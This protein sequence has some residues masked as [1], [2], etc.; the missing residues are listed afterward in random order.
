MKL[1]VFIFLL[2]PNFLLAHEAIRDSNPITNP[3]FT[4]NR[5]EFVKSGYD[6]NYCIKDAILTEKIYTSMKNNVT[7]DEFIEKL[8]YEVDDIA[9]IGKLEHNRMVT[10]YREGTVKHLYNMLDS[11]I[12]EYN[13]NNLRDFIA[14]Q[15]LECLKVN[16]IIMFADRIIE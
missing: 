11:R 15:F 13:I 12:N 10:T 4:F 9:R 1:L 7:Y 2:L 3:Y 8:L 5:Y 16:K 6:L 14:S